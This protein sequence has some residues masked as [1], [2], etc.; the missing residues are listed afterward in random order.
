MGCT[1]KDCNE[2]T[3]EDIIG[4]YVSMNDENK[5]LQ[6]LEVFEGGTYVN[7]YCQNGGIITEKNKWEYSLTGRR[8]SLRPN[9]S[10]EK[11]S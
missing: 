7:T 9:K 5:G 3:E 10:R 6:Y 11:Y 2:I 1:S 8:V 4:F